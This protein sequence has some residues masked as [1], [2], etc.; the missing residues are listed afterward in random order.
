MK[1]Y[2]IIKQPGTTVR[3]DNEFED[4]LNSY[5]KMG[6]RVVNIFKHR[7]FLKALIERNLATE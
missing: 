7:G 3:K 4:L 5:A 2:K 6:W 1:E